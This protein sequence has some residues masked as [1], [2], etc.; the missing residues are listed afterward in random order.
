MPVVCPHMDSGR[1]TRGT[2]SQNTGGCGDPAA[3]SLAISLNLSVASLV[4][5]EGHHCHRGYSP[6]FHSLSAQPGSQGPELNGVQGWG[7]PAPPPSTPSASHMTPLLQPRGAAQGH[8]PSRGCCRQPYP[9]GPGGMAT[10]CS[11][12]PVPSMSLLSLPN[13]LALAAHVEW[14]S[15][16]GSP[17]NQVHPC[18]T[19]QSRS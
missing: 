15:R 16:L 7:S 2:V 13:Q 17:G 6:P 12:H 14:P 8:P 10:F 9:R 11:H 19:D 3:P 18:F 5:N 4:P 1:F